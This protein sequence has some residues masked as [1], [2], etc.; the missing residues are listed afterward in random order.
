MSKVLQIINVRD[1]HSCTTAAQ[2]R[3]ELL[4]RCSTCGERVRKQYVPWEKNLYAV[5]A[6]LRSRNKHDYNHEG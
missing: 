4:L 1:P 2:L 3:C 6:I 5:K